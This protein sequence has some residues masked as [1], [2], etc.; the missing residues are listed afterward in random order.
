MV[1][2][3]T[4]LGAHL[5]DLRCVPARKNTSQSKH[6]TSLWWYPGT[7]RVVRINC[8][9]LTAHGA[10]AAQAQ[11]NGEK[12]IRYGEAA[13]GSPRRKQLLLKRKRMASGEVHSLW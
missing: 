12:S 6:I 1:S 7:P 8:R 11:A 4:A 5:F 13:A 10:T 9:R 2:L 3:R